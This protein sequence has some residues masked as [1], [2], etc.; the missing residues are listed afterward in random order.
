MRIRLNGWQRIGIVLSVVWAIGA[1]YYELG[2]IWERE[3]AAIERRV[4]PPYDLCREAQDSA[5]AASQPFNRDCV[6]ELYGKN[7]PAAIREASANESR[8]TIAVAALAPIPFAWLL[9][10]MLL[11]ISR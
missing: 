7:L 5:M 11:G 3:N 1:A 8:W 2:A 9:A 4:T 10:Y 6:Q